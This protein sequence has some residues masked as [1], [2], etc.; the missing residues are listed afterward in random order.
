MADKN[1]NKIIK[2]L[3]KEILPEDVFQ[4][5]DSRVYYDDNGYYFTIVEFQPYSLMKGTF[6]NVGASFLFDKQDYLSYSYAYDDEVR[7]GKKFIKYIN[8]EQFEKEVREYVELANEYILR[9]R[10][11]KDIYYAKDHIV[12]SLN[13]DNW[14]K[15]IKAMF[16][17]LTDDR[18][19]GIK[20]YKKFIN[21]HFFKR[22]VEQYDYPTDISMMDRDYVIKMIKNKRNMLHNKNYMKK[23]KSFEEYEWDE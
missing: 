9:Y 22:I 7:V 21:A 1:I 3:C 4:K 20:C 6:L 23:M 10:E 14:N 2:A 18:E 11:F 8:D 5:G 12:N 16:Y 19:N 17:F 13:D 15:Y